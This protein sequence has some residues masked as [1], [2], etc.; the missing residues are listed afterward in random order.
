MEKILRTFF[1]AGPFFRVFLTK[2]LSKCANPKKPPLPWKISGCP[3]AWENN[4]KVHV[5]NKR[6][7]WP[8]CFEKILSLNGM[9]MSWYSACSSLVYL[10]RTKG[11]KGHLDGNDF[12]HSYG[13]F[14]RKQYSE[15]YLITAIFKVPSQ[16]SLATLK[17]TYRKIPYSWMIYGH[18]STYVLNI[19][20]RLW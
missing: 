20:S 6:E 7:M 18:G 10:F 13:N 4:T 12:R 14:T 19:L 8:P 15:S 11:K 16:E 5:P 3:P 9:K 17:T 1:P 2:C